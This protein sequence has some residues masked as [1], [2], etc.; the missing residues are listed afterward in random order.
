MDKSESA[1]TPAVTDTAA[2]GAPAPKTIGGWLAANLLPLAFVGGIIALIIWRDLFVSDVALVAVGL[3]LVI[4]IHELGHFI[5]AKLCDVHVETFSIG[6]GKALPGLQFR[7]GETTYKVGWIPLGGY[8]K[9]VGEGDN[10]DT[11]EADEDPRSFKNKSVWQRMVI[12]SAGVIM[13]LILGCICFMVAYSNGVDETPAT[14]GHVTVGS[15]AWQEGV[16]IDTEITQID[17]I[18]RPTFEDIRPTVMSSDKGDAIPFRLRDRHGNEREVNLVPRRNPEDLYPIVGILPIE[19]LVLQKS[20]RS[21]FPPYRLNSPAAATTAAENGSNFEGGDRII[22]SSFDPAKPTVVRELR[23]DPR[24]PNGT[25]YDAVEFFQN[26]HRMRG[27]PMTILVDRDGTTLTFVVPPAWT[28]VLAGVRFQMGRVAALRS[29]G[30]AARAVAVNA[31]GEPGF[32]TAKLDEPGTGDRLIAVEV[33]AIENGKA[34][35]RRYVDE[36]S[37]VAP[38]GVTEVRF[39]PLK[40]P[41]ELEKWA[42]S[43]RDLKVQ[44]TVLR[45]AAGGAKTGKRVTFETKWNPDLVFNGE[46]IGGPSTPMPISGLGLA[47]YVDTTIDS[48]APGPA[49]TAGLAKGDIITQV[50]FREVNEKGEASPDKWVKLKQYQ[51]VALHAYLQRVASPELD[52]MVERQTANGPTEVEITLTAVI[53]LSWPAVDRGLYFPLDTRIQKADGLIDAVKM[54][55][56]RTW[57]TVKVIYQTLYATIFRQISA[58]TMSGPL[59]IANYSYKIAGYDIWQFIIFIGLINI[60]LAIVNFLPIPL[61][62]GGHMVFLIYEKIRGKPAPDK[63]I[64]WSL[65]LGLAFILLLMAFVIFLDVRKLWF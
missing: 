26:Q 14:V 57:R 36:L 4:F 54:G 18:T 6:F 10:A 45:A 28:Q 20:R 41:F 40:L 37:E 30:P 49:A 43:A 3:G 8:V 33:E 25:K 19:Q 29:N 59:T 52:L 21:A 5:A 64:E 22:G 17:D 47:Y 42:E 11:E 60:N 12:I 34:E 31:P 48:V 46:T 50:R 44:L 32:Q 2:N 38:K 55:L 15:P 9:M 16:R 62:D 65:Y 53:D 24:D 39:D 58:E 35:R 61:L 23:K 1:G 7:Y 63:V 13:N 56:H 27:H 51:A